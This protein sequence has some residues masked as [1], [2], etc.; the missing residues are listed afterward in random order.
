MSVEDKLLLQFYH[1]NYCSEFPN[2]F[3]RLKGIV[4]VPL[5]GWIPFT[6]KLS[7]RIAGRRATI[8]EREHDM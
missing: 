8:A 1:Q 7:A 4:N 3:V 5:A 2:L 6:A